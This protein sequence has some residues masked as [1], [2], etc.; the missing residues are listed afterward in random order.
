MHSKFLR[1]LF[2]YVSFPF[3]QRSSCREMCVSVHNGI[4]PNHTQCREALNFTI[5]LFSHAPQKKY[6]EENCEVME[7][8]NT[9]VLSVL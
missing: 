4:H 2:S 7:N 1:F 8:N 3:V 6:T 5:T 9:E